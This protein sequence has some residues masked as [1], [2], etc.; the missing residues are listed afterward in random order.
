M[1]RFSRPTIHYRTAYRTSQLRTPA[2]TSA[3]CWIVK[4]SRNRSAFVSEIVIGFWTRKAPGW[5]KETLTRISRSEPRKAVVRNH[6]DQ[7]AVRVFER[8]VEDQRW[9][10]LLNHSQIHQ[11]NFTASGHGFPPHPETRMSP[12]RL[13]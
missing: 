4:R 8:A 5:R 6:A 1:G 3:N 11:P 13:L 12:R 7:G 2:S 9:P 10:N